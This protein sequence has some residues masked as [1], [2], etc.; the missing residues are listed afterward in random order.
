MLRPLVMWATNAMGLRADRPELAYGA[1]DIDLE[2]LQEFE[3]LTRR[4]TS[5]L[6]SL[7]QYGV[8]GLWNEMDVDEFLD[9]IDFLLFNTQ[10]VGWWTESVRDELESLLRDAG[11]EW[12]VGV[13]D[14]HAGLE[15]RVPEGVVAAVDETITVAGDAGAL[16]AEA[17]RATFGRS[18][19]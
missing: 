2:L 16:L 7:H 3:T 19:D 13:R 5:L 8:A 4:P 15:K 12:A 14:G 18:P 1:G 10:R 6:E 11:S 17:W 9:F